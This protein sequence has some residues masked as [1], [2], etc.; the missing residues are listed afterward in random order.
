MNK[1]EDKKDVFVNLFGGILNNNLMFMFG[2]FVNKFI[3]VNGMSFFFGIVLSIVVNVDFVKNFF[4]NKSGFN[5]VMVLVF[6]FGVFGNVLMKFV[7]VGVFGL[8]VL[9]GS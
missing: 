6:I 5:G 7:N 9:I 3:V 4:D 2:G 8:N 1:V